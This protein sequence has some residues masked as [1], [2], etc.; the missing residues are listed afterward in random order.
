M[1]KLRIGRGFTPLAG[2]KV[3]FLDASP[4]Q[5]HAKLTLEQLGQHL[6]RQLGFY[7]GEIEITTISFSYK[8]NTPTKEDKP[9]A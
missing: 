8:L 3:G 5:D 9:N 1:L 4:E 2:H 6:A 7:D